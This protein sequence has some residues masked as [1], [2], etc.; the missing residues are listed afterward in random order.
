MLIIGLKRG[1][2]VTVGAHNLLMVDINPDNC[3]L[4]NQDSGVMCD[5]N[6]KNWFDLDKNSKLKMGFNSKTNEARIMI[7]APK[8]VVV[9][10]TV[11]WR[12][13]DEARLNWITLFAYKS[14]NEL[15]RMLEQSDVHPD[16]REFNG[17]VFIT[18]GNTVTEIRRVQ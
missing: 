9:T 1:K 18:N 14:F 15:Y 16:G 12:V 7:D 10:K 13:T 5:V 11:I 17:L 6:M 4:K 8:S 3:V 2:S